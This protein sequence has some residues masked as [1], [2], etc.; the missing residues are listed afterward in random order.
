[1]IKSGTFFKYAMS[2]REI[3][4]VVKSQEDREA[5]VPEGVPTLGPIGAKAQKVNDALTAG[6]RGVKE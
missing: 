2:I 6:P 3:H 5:E 4:K 1:M